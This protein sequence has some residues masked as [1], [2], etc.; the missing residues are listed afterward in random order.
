[1]VHA[2]RGIHD[3]RDTNYCE[4]EK[5]KTK[6]GTQSARKQK[7]WDPGNCGPATTKTHQI[8]HDRQKQKKGRR[9]SECVILKEVYKSVYAV[10]VV[11]AHVNRRHHHCIDWFNDQAFFCIKKYDIINIA[12]RTQV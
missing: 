11:S 4:K 7:P 2:L 6:K 9:K 5:T 3:S 12:Y 10:Y 8:T 1:M